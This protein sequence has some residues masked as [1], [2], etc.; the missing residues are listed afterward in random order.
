MKLKPIPTTIYLLALAALVWAC[1][2]ESAPDSTYSAGRCEELAVRIERHDSLTQQDYTDMIGQNE[3][4]LRY[5]VEQARRI[6]ELPDSTRQEAWHLLM[7][8]PEYL[9]RFGYS[10]TLGSTLYQADASGLLDKYNQRL[11]TAL[12]RYNKDLA[13]YS[14]R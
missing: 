10:F 8:D 11:Y 14:D 9:E 2:Y 3:A 13:Q 7:A 12:D 5:L 4:I 6:S 1:G